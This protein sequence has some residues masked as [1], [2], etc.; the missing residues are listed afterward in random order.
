MSALPPQERTVGQLVAEAIRVY[1][2]QPLAALALGVGPAVAGVGAAAIPDGARLV[3]ALSVG[4]LLVS[5]SF[6]AASALVARAR[7]D[8]ATAATAVA[9]GVLVLL[10]AP[11]LATLFVLP[12]VAYLAVVG[13]VV[14]V[15]VVERA[16]FGEAFRRAVSLFFADPIHAIGSL[17]TLVIIGLLTSFVLFFLLRDQGEAT[18]QV[19]GFLSVLVI[20]PLLFLGSAVLYFDQAARVGSR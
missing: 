17:A 9:A 16:G 14:P 20:S 11:F 6:A 10:P 3:W 2:E 15:A 12:A 1:G 18:L 5:A 19:A 8:P 7:P 4:A 13:L